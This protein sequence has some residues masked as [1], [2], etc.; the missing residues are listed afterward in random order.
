VSPRYRNLAL[1]VALLGLAA[2]GAERLR[3]FE[4]PPAP[5]VTSPEAVD[6]GR[7]VFDRQCRH[8]HSDIP[9]ERRVAGWSLER[10]YATLGR[11]PE[12]YPAMPP[13]RGTDEERRALAAFLAALGRGD[14]R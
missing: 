7:R 5:L 14:R 11:L 1:A 3:L 6:R 8:C 4:P 2:I 12:V 13:F 10:A 9:L